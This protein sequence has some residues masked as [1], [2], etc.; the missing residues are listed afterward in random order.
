MT[1]GKSWKVLMKHPSRTALFTCVCC[2]VG[3]LFGSAAA[4]GDLGAAFHA[5]PIDTRVAIQSELAEVDLYL[6]DPDGDWSAATE[7]AVLR[8]VET[9][10]LNSGDRVHPKLKTT[11]SMQIYLEAL[12]E[13]SY[14]TYLRPGDYSA[15]SAFLRKIHLGG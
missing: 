4:A 8:S 11:Q 1:V 14:S 7:R 15:G 2:V 9:I 6:A 13:G 12:A 5:L 3:A 10:A